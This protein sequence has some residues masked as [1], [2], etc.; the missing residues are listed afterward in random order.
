MLFQLSESNLI[1]NA[2]EFGVA[3]V[4][5]GLECSNEQLSALLDAEERSA[6]QLERFTECFAHSA[7][8]NA[9]KRLANALREPVL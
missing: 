5:R 7:D 6:E 2:R 4:V 3:T 9:T 1:T 8:G